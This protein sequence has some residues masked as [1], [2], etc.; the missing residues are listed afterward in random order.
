[1]IPK[2]PPSIQVISEHP[3]LQMVSS[4]PI[5]MV[6]EAPPISLLT[7]DSAPAMRELAALANPRF[8][9]SRTHQL[10]RYFAI[11][12]GPRLAAMAGERLA[13]GPYREVSGVCTHPDFRHRGYAR[14]LIS[15]VVNGIVGEGNLAFLHVDL[16]AEAAQTLYRSLGFVDANVV[17]MVL[18]RRAEA[19]PEAKRETLRQDRLASAPD[20]E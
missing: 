2:L 3:V 13:M 9:R 19:R 6:G 14:R 17:P 20:L 4:G 18:V 11:L 15:Q 16:G 7:E 8:F 1:M 10:G 5:P 12:Q